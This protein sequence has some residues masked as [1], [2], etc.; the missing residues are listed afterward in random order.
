MSNPALTGSCLLSLAALFHRNGHVR[1]QNAQRLTA[2]GWQHYKK[3]DEIRFTAES[4]EELN[5]IRRWLRA[6]G[7]KPGRPLR[8]GR[9]M[10]QPV[11]GREDVQQLLNLLGE[12][13]NA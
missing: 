8:K 1:W 2:E 5:A 3:G 12:R 4:A 9:Q 13:H 6:L 10:R 11:Y 7:F